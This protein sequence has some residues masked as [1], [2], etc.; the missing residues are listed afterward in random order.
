M[1]GI[2]G[3]AGPAATK[4]AVEDMIGRLTH[5]GPDAGAVQAIGNSV[6]GHRRLA[7]V[8]LS[9]AGNQP[10]TT[11]DGQLALVANGEIY[12]HLDLR[13]ELEAKGHVFGSSSDNEV[14]LHG[15]RE[16]GAALFGRINGMFACALW[17]GRS[18]DLIL[19][20]DRMGIKPVFYRQAEDSLFFASELKALLPRNGTARLSMD[21]LAQFLTLQNYLDPDTIIDGVRMLPPGS[22]LRFRNGSLH[23]ESYWRASFSE[24]AMA[25]ETALP[26][27]AEAFRNELDSSVRR[28]LMS[29]VPVSTYLSAGLDS[30][31]VTC[32]AA[33][34]EPGLKAFT[35]RFGA[36]GWYDE[37]SGAAMVARHCGAQHE[38]LDIGPQDFAGHLDDLAYHLDQPRMGMGSF[39][40]Y[41]LAGQVAR[42]HKVVLTGHGGDELFSGYPIF[43]VLA[44]HARLCATPLEG[45][46]GLLSVRP[47]ELPHLAYFW[48]GPW[49]P[50][51]RRQGLP[52]LFGGGEL[53][54]LLRPEVTSNVNLDAVASRLESKVEGGRSD[55][56]RLMLTYLNVYLPGLLA[57]EDG[58]SMAHSVES[59]VPLLDNNM[60]AMALD[61]SPDLKLTGW[62]T[63][64][65]PREALQK[66]LPPE[67]FS[68]P[69][70]GFPT[71]LRLWLREELR[72]WMRARLHPDSSPLVT[73]FNPDALKNLVDAFDRSLSRYARPFDE[74]K[75]HRMWMLLCMDAWL[76]QLQARL[77]VTVQA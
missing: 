6:L 33:Q 7:I 17:D 48:P 1:C 57:V 66:V 49:Q 35:G 47:A 73:I 71:P 55:Y 29:D 28:H 15:W 31:G 75:G 65:I 37:A 42:T 50:P 24:S 62:R 69:K 54:R 74:I 59:R 5:R 63:K 32:A 56:E 44:L 30:S 36:G 20:R 41:M 8:D 76:R 19:A 51:T 45:L 16:W 38:V 3:A 21:G 52:V 27:A 23:S 60:V 13:R 70:R 53:R 2:G 9:E 22:F 39:P 43:K 40:Q 68:M 72:D 34:I 58:I 64:A 77:G 61:L 11:G 12:N 25:R 10:M 67:L 46:R 14:L 26:E 4:A 18:G